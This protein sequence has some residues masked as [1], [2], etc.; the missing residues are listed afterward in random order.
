[1]DST[2]QGER[3]KM[4]TYIGITKWPNISNMP[5]VIGFLLLIVDCFIVLPHDTKNIASCGNT[6]TPR[7]A[8]CGFVG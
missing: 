8:R 6:K 7:N 2:R 4:K 1:M 3:G 5:R